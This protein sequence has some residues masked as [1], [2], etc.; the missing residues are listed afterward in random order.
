MTFDLGWALNNGESVI[1][2]AWLV[3][4]ILVLLASRRVME[5]DL[6]EAVIG[7]IFWPFVFVLVLAGLLYAAWLSLSAQ[8]FYTKKRLAEWRARP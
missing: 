6:G 7:A 2:A 8:W 1:V 4:T 3:G 5:G